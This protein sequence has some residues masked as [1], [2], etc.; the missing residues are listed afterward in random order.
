VLGVYCG[1][2]KKFSP[3]KSFGKTNGEEHILN[4][5]QNERL[6]HLIS[7]IISL[8]NEA[9]NDQIKFE[10]INACNAISQILKKNDE[11]IMKLLENFGDPN[12]L[13]EKRPD[14]QENEEIVKSFSEERPPLSNKRKSSK[15]NNNSEYIDEQQSHYDKKPPL[16][17]Q[18]P[19]FKQSPKKDIKIDN[20]DQYDLKENAS[21]KTV[22]NHTKSFVNSRAYASPPYEEDENQFN[23]DRSAVSDREINNQKVN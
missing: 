10:L 21:M 2:L 6:I 15:F 5:A 16:G 9:L 14:S 23:D 4:E 13:L 11:K 8:Q 1:N 18:R 19:K 7:E 22:K 20:E 3:K 12:E 17:N